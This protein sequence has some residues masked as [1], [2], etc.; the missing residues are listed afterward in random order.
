MT[1]Q[2]TN[3]EYRAP[4]SQAIADLKAEARRRAGANRYTKYTND[5]VGFARDVLGLTVWSRQAEVLTAA[6]QHKQTAIR[7]GR[8][9]SKSTNIATLALWNS[10][11]RGQPTLLTSSSYSQ[12]KDIIWRELDRLSESAKLGLDIP[13]DPSTGVRTP[14]GGIISGRSTNKREYM[15]GYSGHDALY[16]ADEASGLP[17]FIVEA[18]EGNLAGGGRLMLFGN[19]TQ[20]SGPFYDAFH[21]HRASWHTI[22]ISSRESPNVTGEA[23]I[24]GLAL[25]DW[26]TEQEEKHGADSAFVQIHVDGDF[27]KT[28]SNTVISLALVE[29]AMSR[30]LQPNP[31]ERLHIGVDAARYGSDQTTVRPRRGL[32]ALP[33]RKARDTDSH[34]IANLVLE[35]IAQQALPAERPVVKVDVIGIGAGAYDVLKNDYGHLMDV[36]PVNVAERATTQPDEGGYRRLRDQLWFGMR[37]WLMEGG[38]VPQDEETRSDLIAATFRFDAQGRYVVSDKDELRKLIGR[39]PDEADGL[40]LSIYDPPRSSLSPADNLAAL[41]AL[42]RR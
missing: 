19:P 24:P 11:A 41:R 5:P 9:I 1:L 39:S 16:L 4:L 22:R 36:I 27:P 15:Q 3:A 31:A 28:G 34:D 10:M 2:A 37:D 30:D 6:V 26:I 17:T 29:A 35:V 7:G 18:L 38:S 23:A 8:K 20:L 13:L 12:L 33:S 14:G 25:P 42:N 21:T 40:A 32:V